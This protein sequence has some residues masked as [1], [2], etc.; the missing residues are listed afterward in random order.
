[1]H[2]SN[3]TKKMIRVKKVAPR[4]HRSSPEICGAE[5]RSQG[6][7]QTVEVKGQPSLLPHMRP[8]PAQHHHHHHPTHAFRGVGSPPSTRRQQ[9]EEHPMRGA[10]SPKLPPFAGPAAAAALAQRCGSTRLVR[11]GSTGWCGAVRPVLLGSVRITRENKPAD[12][13]AQS[14]VKRG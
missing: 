12:A 1:M 13:Q 11:C 2:H 8:Q 4:V 6:G 9:Q 3:R 7:S 14:A 10:P 5:G